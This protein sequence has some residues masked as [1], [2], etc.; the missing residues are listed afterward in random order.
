MHE[1]FSNPSL[2]SIKPL[3]IIGYIF[4][5]RGTVVPIVTSVES[6]VK[7]SLT[8]NLLFSW[9]GLY[10]ACVTTLTGAFCSGHRG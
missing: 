4:I 7:M 1:M 10:L 6:P 5:F 3:T 8:G 2:I 9:L